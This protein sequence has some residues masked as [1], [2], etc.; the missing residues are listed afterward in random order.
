VYID[1]FI[2]FF[3]LLFIEIFSF[4]NT[5]TSLRILSSY[6]Q[7]TLII[8]G[9]GNQ[10][11]LNND[12]YMPYKILVNDEIQNKTDIIVYDLKKEINNVTLVWDHLFDDC[13]SM[14]EKLNNII[15][16]D[17]SKFDTSEVTSMWAMFY[18]CEKLKYINLKYMNTS[19][20]NNPAIYCI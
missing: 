7:I 10:Q 3:Q 12:K 13:Y 1:I 18:H 8:N 20:L 17:C 14:F 5:K 4:K 19:K 6:S 9:K 15:Q 16:I 11:I 2:I